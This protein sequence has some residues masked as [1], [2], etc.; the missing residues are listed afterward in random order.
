MINHLLDSL[1]TEGYKQT[2]LRSFLLTFLSHKK[3]PYTA[4]ELQSFAH[5]KIGSIH[6]TSIYREL[7]FLVKKKILTEIFFT[8]GVIRYE[9][10]DLPH[11]HHLV[12]RNCHNIEDIVVADELQ[13]LEKSIRQEKSFVIERHSLEFFGLCRI[14]QS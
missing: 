12:C 2:K 8:D 13:K 7:E 1:Q 11:H 4:Q 14:C 3:K 6:K 9:L 10:T 5:R